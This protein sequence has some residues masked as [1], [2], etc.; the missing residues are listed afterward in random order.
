MTLSKTKNIA[1]QI[2]LPY[3]YRYNTNESW[4]TMGFNC[5]QL[6]MPYSEILLN[7]Y[8]SIDDIFTW[9]YFVQS[10]LLFIND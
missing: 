3:I 7:L 8:I 4:L 2:S 5:N 10:Y 9:N 1:Y 6:V